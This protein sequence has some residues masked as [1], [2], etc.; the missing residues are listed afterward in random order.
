[1]SPSL[2]L[3]LSFHQDTYLPVEVSNAP[4]DV[5]TDEPANGEVDARGIIEERRRLGEVHEK[6]LPLVEKPTPQTVAE[7][8]APE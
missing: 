7:T 6:N 2:H 1:M 5:G 3:F 8:A 4:T